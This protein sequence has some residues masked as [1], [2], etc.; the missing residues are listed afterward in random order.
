MQEKVCDCRLREQQQ[1]RGTHLH[2][3]LTYMGKVIAQLMQPHP[4]A[5]RRVRMRRR[6]K[7]ISQSEIGSVWAIAGQI[8]PIRRIC[9]QSVL[10]LQGF[11]PIRRCNKQATCF[12]VLSISQFIAEVF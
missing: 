7:S 12:P 1:N 4:S 2:E 3:P 8:L 9:Q 5:K 6:S 11:E 10:G